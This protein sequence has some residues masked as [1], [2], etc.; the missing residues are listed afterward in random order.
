ME[1]AT[2]SEAERRRRSAKA[3]LRRIFDGLRPGLRYRLWDGHEGTIGEPDGSWTLVVRDR[4]A[5]RAAFSTRNTR[6]MAEAFVDDRIDVEGDL[7]AALRF[8]NQIED[9]SLGLLD[10]LGIW[11]DLREV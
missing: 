7:F 10:K 2:T 9:Q 3:V 8:A 11:L 4:D 6:V 1:S 5:F